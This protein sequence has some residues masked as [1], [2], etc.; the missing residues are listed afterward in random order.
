[1]K[2]RVLALLLSMSILA[3]PVLAAEEPQAQTIAPW[4]QDAMSECAALGMW[5]ES[6]IYH[7]EDEITD[8][9]LDRLCTAVAD[10]LA[11][12][13]ME[14]NK[15]NAGPEV[16]V[17]DHTRGGVMNA[18]YKELYTYHPDFLG[19][20]DSVESVMTDMMMELG[21]S[22]VLLGDETGNLHLDRACTLQE[23][24]V[25]SQRLVLS[26]Y[27]YYD[28]GSK[29]LLWKAEGNGNTLYLL[30][31]IHVDR[32]NVYPF[33][34]TLR[35]AITS[36]EL[37]ALE[38]D[39]GDQADM[40]AFVKLQVYDD[41]TTLADHVSPELRERVSEVFL[42][43]GMTQEQVD[44]YRPWVLAGSL[45]QLAVSDES[46]GPVVLPVDSYVYSKAMNNGLT[47]DGI[48]SH[49]YQAK[50]IFNSLSDEY[51]EGYLASALDSYENGAAGEADESLDQ[52]A[53]MMEVWK[54]GD[55]A[56]FN[57][58]YHKE[59]ILNSDDEL[60]VKLFT[61]RDPGMIAYAADYLSQEDGG[62]TGF[63][64][65]GAGHMVG[66][67]GVVQGLLDLGYTV[68]FL[69]GQA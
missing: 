19:W 23:A 55:L 29:G 20:S 35:E 51:Q 43:M 38:V 48:E 53:A 68:E 57:E 62:H 26:L 63:V 64:A 28:A 31:T 46:T 11:V 45:T 9:Q 27:D 47:V 15:E 65:V 7:V 50:E 56:G 41:G 61:D 39:F 25:M 49:V 42:A 66:E 59:A 17:I 12:L 37:L 33:S 40:E 16:G 36:S 13:G 18:L 1:M 54:T 3:L 44:A 10:K 2:R 67:T 52:I 21:Q 30:G 22:P 24:L 58:L 6:D 8:Q 5:E 34:K 32:G 69:S 14:E 60:S 4:A